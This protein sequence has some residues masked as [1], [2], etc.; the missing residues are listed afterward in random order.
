MT[1]GSQRDRDRDRAQ[2]RAETKKKSGN[3]EGI[4]VVQRKERDA[5]I[6]RQK[7]EKAAAK[8]LAESNNKS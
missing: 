3:S 4:S 6:M 8:K 7:L 2:K 5:D 1:R